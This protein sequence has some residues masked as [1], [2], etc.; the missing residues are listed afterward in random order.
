MQVVLCL[1]EFLDTCSD[2]P[3]GATVD[4]NGCADSQKDTDGDG[5]NDDIDLCSDS[6]D[7]ATVD[8]N[9]CADSQK[10]TDGDGIF[11]DVDNCPLISNPDQADWNNNGVGDI[12]GDPKPLFTEK[13]TFV[14]NIYPNPTDNKLIVIVK[15][16]L[17]IK[18]LYFVD[19]SGKTIRP[20]SISRTHN[21]LDINVSNLNKGVYI[22]EIVSDKEVDKVKVVIER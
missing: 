19:F 8:A 15:P 17:E 4:A 2:S 9:G 11:D 21:N 18:D 12:C 5:V 3:D 16:G 20:R 6:P 10:D 22:L 1:S 13:V 7:G 14:E